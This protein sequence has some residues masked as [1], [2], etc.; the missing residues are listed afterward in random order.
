[1]IYSGLYLTFTR[2]VKVSTYNC[3]PGSDLND[4]TYFGYQLP[5]INLL[6]GY[7]IY[8]YHFNLLEFKC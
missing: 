5:I 1:M 7:Y 6:I 2:M 4:F 8:F 3:F